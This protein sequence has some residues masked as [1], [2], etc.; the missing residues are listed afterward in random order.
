MNDS[1]IIS[2]LNKISFKKAIWLAPVL[3]I[4]HFSEELTL[5]F[6]LFQQRNRGYN[7]PLEIFVGG[8]ILILLLLY[9]LNLTYFTHRPTKLNAFIVL[10]VFSAAQFANTFFHLL[11]TILFL[12]YCPG[13]I[14]AF[15]MYIPYVPIMFWIAYREKLI[16]KSLI[17]ITLILGFGGMAIFEIE[18]AAI[19]VIL[20]FPVFTIVANYIDKHKTKKI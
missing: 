18:G 16:T 14:T 5:G 15:I 17:I 2:V 12:E 4:I 20:A 13:L 19:I 10:L 8:N 6:Y 7:I 1:K 3:Y 9:V 11:W